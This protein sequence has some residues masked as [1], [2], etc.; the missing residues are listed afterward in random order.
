MENKQ[1]DIKGGKSRVT[2]RFF[3]WRNLSGNVFRRKKQSLEDRIAKR[4]KFQKEHRKY[5]YIYRPKGR[6]ISLKGVSRIA[7][8][9]SES[10]KKEVICM[11]TDVD[12]KLTC[13]T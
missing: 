3:K 2:S 9:P 4:T 5:F 10:L 12:T 8:Y 1:A 13:C 7:S 11:I 6:D